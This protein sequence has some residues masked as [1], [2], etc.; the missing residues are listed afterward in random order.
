MMALQANTV[1]FN[2]MHRKHNLDPRHFNAILRFDWSRF[3][4]TPFIA[5]FEQNA[6]FASL[7]SQS[8]CYVG[9]PFYYSTA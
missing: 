6:A 2:K 9:Y 1:N 5:W 8:A 7:G 4:A 3:K